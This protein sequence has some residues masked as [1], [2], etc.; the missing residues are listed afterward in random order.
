MTGDY[1]ANQAAAQRHWRERHRAYW[2]RYRQRRPQYAERNRERQGERNRRRRSAG[3]APAPP[4]IA[5]MDASRAQ[6][7]FRSGTY[8]RFTNNQARFQ[9]RCRIDRQ[10][11]DQSPDEQAPADALVTPGRGPA[12]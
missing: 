1:R 9:L 2:R 8:G 11:P 10:L 4:G 5:N 7:P 3:T 6:T 12:P